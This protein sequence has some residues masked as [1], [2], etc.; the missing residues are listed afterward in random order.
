MFDHEAELAVSLRSGKP[1][2]DAEATATLQ[3]AKHEN[4]ICTPHNAFNTAESLERK[5]AHSVK[6]VD[7]FLK[8]GRFVWEVPRT[9]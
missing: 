1:S 3:L 9:S 8:T 6:Q 4:V 2:S 7:A 5:S